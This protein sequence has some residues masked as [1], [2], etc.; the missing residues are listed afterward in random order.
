[1]S[2]SSDPVIIER[3][4]P[5]TWTL[6]VRD[7][8]TDQVHELELRGHGPWK[9]DLDGKTAAPG[10]K[11][12]RQVAPPPDDAITL[13]LERAAGNV[14]IGATGRGAKVWSAAQ[15]TLLGSKWFLDSMGAPV[16]VLEDRPTLVAEIQAALPAVTLDLSKYTADAPTDEPASAP[17]PRPTP[18]AEPA[19][20][21]KRGRRGKVAAPPDADI[22]L[23]LSN[24]GRTDDMVSIT[25]T[26]LRKG[27]DAEA[28]GAWV[29][30][31]AASL[32]SWQ[33]LDGTQGV[34]VQD[35]RALP[36]ELHKNF[37]EVR[38]DVSL[39]FRPGVKNSPKVAPGEMNYP[40]VIASLDRQDPRAIT[41]LHA[42]LRQLS[43]VFLVV[44]LVSGHGYR[45]VE[46][47]TDRP[48]G[49]YDGLP[50]GTSLVQVRLRHDA[51]P[52][53]SATDW[54]PLKKT[55]RALG[56]PE[57]QLAIL[58]EY[59][60]ETL[61]KASRAAREQTSEPAPVAAPPRG[62]KKPKNEPAAGP[63]G[64]SWEPVTDSG[65]E[66]LVARWGEG[67]FKLLHVGGDKYGLFYEHDGGGFETLGCG[68]LA[69]GKQA[70]GDRV[71][72]TRGGASLDARAAE[73]A[74]APQ[75]K[76]GLPEHGE[77]TLHVRRSPE[78]GA[79]VVIRATGERVHE[80][81]FAHPSLMGHAWGR[82]EH[83]TPEV[84]ADDSPTLI[85]DLRK[86][87]PG[88]NI[89]TSEI[90]KPRR[91]AKPEPLPVEAAPVEALPEPAASP[92]P[93][94]PPVA[95][96]AGDEASQDAELLRSI[97]GQLADM[98]DE[99]D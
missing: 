8:R 79:T 36:E 2:D 27:V 39:Y 30:R 6:H 84:T 41:I 56:R 99:E 73:L 76:A 69:E 59:V 68:S 64:L 66:G 49:V 22:R 98:L 50:I 40:E 55:L 57:K 21:P 58:R 54:A 90:K 37:P 35:R 72:G 80:W 33:P 44:P 82:G 95:P 77:I 46:L 74:C 97:K 92:E 70:A 20:A 93:E 43:E 47:L 65:S 60:T 11:A 85:A 3:I 91:T 16:V 94:P 1:M 12:P 96:P 62:R 51:D 9:L 13:R 7:T 24:A 18:M 63:G 5:R 38:L 89:E 88:V 86:E 15:G 34:L 25:A 19:A 23:V 4:E 17:P 78:D 42:V 53:L 14:R 52:A 71:A 10:G 31:R 29:E 28:L 26:G 87:F 48:T 45:S 32:G 81:V 75:R 83:N 61:L 67:Q